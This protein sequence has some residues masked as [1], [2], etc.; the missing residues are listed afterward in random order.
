MQICEKKVLG[1][2]KLKSIYKKGKVHGKNTEFLNMTNC[3]VFKCSNVSN[4]TTVCNSR[5]CS[6]GIFKI[7][8]FL[9]IA[10]EKKLFREYF[11]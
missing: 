1:V 11:E 3:C 6:K 7:I 4:A 5:R 8:H 9:K 2:D 10:E